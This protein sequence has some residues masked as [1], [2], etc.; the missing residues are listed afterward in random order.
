MQFLVLD[1]NFLDIQ[2]LDSFDSFIWTDRYSAWGDFEIY[3]SP[4]LENLS[5][6]QQDYYIWFEET[7][8]TMI[9]EDLRI[10]SDAEDGN[11][12]I[13][14]G[15][16]LESMLERRII[17]D[18]T[19]LK[20]N[21]Q[22][23]IK[24]LISDSIIAP[25]SSTRTAP[26]NVRIPNFKFEF[27]T[28]PLITKLTIDTQ[29]TGANLYETIKKLCDSNNLGFRIILSPND[30]FVFSL[31]SGSDRSYNQITNPY[32]IFSPNFDNLINSNYF[33]SKRALKTVALVAGEG[34]GLERRKIEVAI[35]NG[36]GVGLDRRELYTDAR[37]ISS[38]NGE[39]SEASYKEQ[40]TQRGRN[41]LAENIVIKAFEG[42]VD[43]VHKFVFNKDFFMGDIV[44]IANEYGIEAT[45]RVTEVVR[46]RD[47]EGFEVFPT[48]KTIE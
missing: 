44:Q 33:A 14:T 3:L 4:T 18:Q 23:G 9:I 38:N 11:K 7:D 27:S 34:E 2:V 22:E 10:T 47:V 48:F 36:P 8:H 6:L 45:S 39:I 13:V 29:F 24:K 35:D 30:E 31:Y 21:F 25:Q 41:Y 37:D 32:V 5:F 28:N 43:T 17:W 46:S 16:S 42:H 20:G 15:R 1:R 26:A 19:I 40:L 12:L